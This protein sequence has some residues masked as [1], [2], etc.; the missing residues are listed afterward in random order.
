[1]N[2]N[3]D[4]FYYRMFLHYIF[5]NSEI[6]RIKDKKDYDEKKHLAYELLEICVE[7]RKKI[8]P[9]LKYNSFRKKMAFRLL[10]N[11]MTSK[12]TFNYFSKKLFKNS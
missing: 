6:A 1:M 9:Y 2:I 7:N 3:I 12:C 11:P 10:L 8:I 5:I 4:E